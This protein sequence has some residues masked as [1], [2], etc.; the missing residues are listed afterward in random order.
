MLP[1]TPLHHLLMAR[2]AAAARHE[3]RQPVR[4]PDRAPRRG[5]LRPPRAARRRCAGARPPDPHPLRRL[6]RAGLRAPAADGAAVPRLRA[7]A[8]AAS[9]PGARARCSPSAPSSRTPCRWPRTRCWSASH[10]IGDLEHLATYQAFLQATAHLCRLFGIEPE[11]VAHDLHPEYLST[12][13]ALDLDL[14]PWPVQ[15]HHAHIASCLA[16][17][18]ARRAPCSGSPSTAS[19]TGPTARCGAGSSSS[20]TSTASSG[21]AHLRPG[22]P[23]RGTAAIREPWRMALAWTALAAGPDA[24]ARLGAGA[25]S[26]LERGA[27]PGARG[28]RK[29]PWRCAPPAPAACSTPWPPSSGLRSRITYEGQ[30]AIELETLARSVPRAG[31]AELSRLTSSRPPVPAASTCSTRL[32]SSPPC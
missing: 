25:R 30:A 26:A 13:Y 10:H 19:A 7:R 6:G 28:R 9:T 20:P 18:G 2:M 11:V 3:Q 4:R 12:K 5:R 16:E 27:R 21:S 15:H 29:R 17:H 22:R 31:R 23:A 14:E 8:L 24:A 1:Y 32:P